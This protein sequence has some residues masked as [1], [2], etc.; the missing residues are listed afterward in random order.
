MKDPKET[1]N[2]IEHNTEMALL[3]SEKIANSVDSLE[4][5]MEGMLVK[6]DEIVEELKKSNE[7]KPIESP[8]IKIEGG[9]VVTL[10][11]RDGKDGEKG[12]K[13]EKGDKGE[14]GERG[15]KGEA[16]KDG[17]DGMPGDHGFD[18]K[19]GRDGINGLPGMQGKAGRDGKDGRDG[20]DG[21]DGSP[22]TGEQ[23]KSKL[24]KLKVGLDYDSLSNVPDIAKIARNNSSKTV[25]LTELDDVDYSGLT[26]ENGRYVLGSGE[27]QDINVDGVTI[28]GNGNDEP[29]TAV[30]N[31]S[32][33]YLISGGAV[34]SGTGFIYDV[35]TLTYFFNGNHTSSPTQVTLAASDATYDRFDAVVVTE[36][37]VV[38]VVTGTPAADPA[39]PTLDDDELLV[40][41]ILVQATT[42]APTPT[43]DAIY[44]D[45]TEWT[46]S[47]Y[48]AATPA[49][50]SINFDA[51][52][53]PKQGTKLISANTDLRLG[54][55]FVRASNIDLTTYTMLTVWVR[56]NTAVATNKSLNVRFENTAGALTG[57]TVNLFTYGLSRTLLNTWQLVVVPTYAFGALTLV[58]GLKVIMAGGTV[59]T[60]TNWDLDYMILTNGSTPQAN[61][62]TVTVQQS[63][64]NKGT[65]STLNFIGATVTDDPTNNRINVTTGGTPAG[66]DTQV[67]YN[68]AG[69]FGADS[70]FTRSYLGKDFG[71]GL[72]GGTEIGNILNTIFAGSVTGIGNTYTDY[73]N[74][75][76]ASLW[77]GKN[78]SGTNDFSTNMLGF[79]LSTN[80]GYSLS[81]SLDG[82]YSG[83]PQIEF[84]INGS[85]N[86]SGNFRLNST[87]VAFLH[88]TLASF[89]A[90]TIKFG[91]SKVAS[92]Y[93]IMPATAGASGSILTGAGNAGTATWQ[94]LTGGALSDIPITLK[95][96][97]DSTNILGLN[98]T[99]IQLI[100]APGAGK[101][102]HILNIIGN[103]VSVAT[104]YATN[105]T[106][107]VFYGS[108]TTSVYEDTNLLPATSD[109]LSS[110]MPQAVNEVNANNAVN[111][112]VADGNPTD[113][114]GLLDIY[115]TY[116]VVTL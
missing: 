66:S 79:N 36:T 76:F 47:T 74:N 71:S 82:G 34:W 63:G 70:Y 75:K 37:G 99:P 102:I 18:G 98:S 81:A 26:Q 57:S 65:R 110:F 41:Y 114:D 54:A 2:N 24:E 11:G 4:P 68:N 55:R 86:E 13:G 80:K 45:N 25:S 12:E 96:Q 91:T 19:D 43:Q 87:N 46:T 39:T 29:L 49:T 15:E 33:K 23:I 35:S 22:D 16:G 1:F 107:R 105:T 10:K 6:T 67:Q 52:N 7:K 3:Q 89:Y 48:T 116:K 115:V 60:T 62:P 31:Q 111:I 27:P 40:Q 88:E 53:T 44:L 9:E 85:P 28:L 56:F 101:V 42:T 64:T 93:W 78:T 69:V 97:L 83:G 106:L 77:V 61:V 20:V 14:K 103:I 51:T 8:K 73:G 38:S 104:S 21:K 50:G 94:T 84:G 72:L 109:V 92:D 113:G 95:V 112:S 32:G 5:I 90:P 30:F 59:G 17:L 100:A 58:K 108:S